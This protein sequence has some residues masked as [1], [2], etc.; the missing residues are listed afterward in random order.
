MRS[1]AIFAPITLWELHQAQV[2]ELTVKAARRGEQVYLFQCREAARSCAINEAHD[3]TICLECSIQ[4][5]R[6]RKILKPY[7]SLVEIISIKPKDLNEI[8]I[9]IGFNHLNFR[10][11]QFF[12]YKN[13]P[14]G[15][16]VYGD[17]IAQT[18]DIFLDENTIG[19][20]WRQMLHNSIQLYEFFLSKLNSLD[21]SDVWI[22]NGRRAIDAALSFASQ[23]LK[24]KRRYFNLGSSHNTMTISENPISQLD[25]LREEIE[26]WRKKREELGEKE[27]MRIEGEKF[28]E[29][30]RAGNHP[31]PNFINFMTAHNEIKV[32]NHGGK[33]RRTLV[34]FTSSMWEYVTSPEF[35]KL[36]NEFQDMYAV[37]AQIVTN[38]WILENY[39]LIV[40][41]HPNLLNAGPGEIQKQREIIQKSPN[42]EH[43]LQDSPINSYSLL[44]LA[45]VVVTC[46]ST[47]G[48]ESA[49]LSIPSILLGTSAYRGLGV[50]YE[51]KTFQEFV[52]LL[53]QQLKP[54]PQEGVWAFGDWQKNA[55]ILNENVQYER[56]HYFLQGNWI[57]RKLPISFKLLRWMRSSDKITV[58]IKIK[59]FVVKK[60][61][62][63][64]F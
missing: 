30:V 22:W 18:R 24:T 3:R 56:D 46:G 43:I 54:L 40:R 48:I 11:L 5:S 13:Y 15:S 14:F 17:L 53:S 44:D 20:K 34:V 62:I 10:D 59:K 41:W 58:F 26:S 64:K 36:E 37:Y 2:I 29:L 61:R 25:G 7:D 16:Y 27:I 35:R 57:F 52:R 1:H 9:E 6:T 4:F 60:L 19:D 47:M 39:H 42:I 8:K 33:K 31:R 12:T 51:P 38:E 28:Y 50:V 55:G 63:T 23:E 49:A 21:V 45:D 32:Q